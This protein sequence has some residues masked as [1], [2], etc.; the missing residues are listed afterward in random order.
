MRHSK[1]TSTWK[2]ASRLPAPAGVRMAARASGRRAERV[3]S[4]ELPCEFPVS[5][6]TAV[7]DRLRARRGTAEANGD[8]RVQASA[9]P[10]D[11]GSVNPAARPALATTRPRARSTRRRDCSA[12]SAGQPRSR[13]ALPAED[14]ASNT[15][16]YVASVYRSNSTY[17]C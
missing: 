7:R 15:A 6:L 11:A 14:Y 13:P 1:T 2:Q 17:A 9:G 5:A 12:C 10:V 3:W 16:Q 4:T 8:H